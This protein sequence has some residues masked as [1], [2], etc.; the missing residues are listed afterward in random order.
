[1]E[2][3][4]VSPI[5]LSYFASVVPLVVKVFNGFCPTTVHGKGSQSIMRECTHDSC[6][7][8]D[9]GQ[10]SWTVSMECLV[11]TTNCTCRSFGF[12][13]GSSVARLCGRVPA[14]A[15]TSTHFKRQANCGSSILLHRAMDTCF[16]ALV[17]SFRP[18]CALSCAR[19]HLDTVQSL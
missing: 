13:N 19:I 16:H 12:Y 2:L 18:P 1:M 10:C 7:I 9:E 3:K 4:Y 15:E 11:L 17:A 14:K 6:A 8:N 5:K